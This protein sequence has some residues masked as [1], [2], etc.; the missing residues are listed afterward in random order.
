VPEMDRCILGLHTPGQYARAVDG[1]S[2]A[3]RLTALDARV[4]LGRERRTTGGP[5]SL[6]G[7]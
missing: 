1:G 3:L 5:R 2:I 6:P 7:A 4:D